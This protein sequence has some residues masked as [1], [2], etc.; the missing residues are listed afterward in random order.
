MEEKITQQR[1][2]QRTQ[3]PSAAATTTTTT[4][5]NIRSQVVVVTSG[6][7]STSRA[8]T[9][10][11]VRSDSTSGS[12]GWM[13]E[14]GHSSAK[15]PTTP[16]Q[17]SKRDSG[18]HTDC[19]PAPFSTLSHF[20]FDTPETLPEQGTLQGTSFPVPRPSL[21]LSYAGW[22]PSRIMSDLGSDDE[23][24]DDAFAS[25]NVPVGATSELPGSTVTLASS[26]RPRSA[27]SRRGQS[28]STS[29]NED[30][31]DGKADERLTSAL[32]HR[33]AGGRGD[34][35]SA[36]VGNS[37]RNVHF[38]AL[39]YRVVDHSDD[40][41]EEEEGEGVS[42]TDYHHGPLSMVTLPGGERI[43]PLLT[44]TTAT[45]TPHLH[46]QLIDQILAYPQEFPQSPNA[47]G[48]AV[49]RLR[50]YSEGEESVNVSSLTNGP[51]PDIV[52]VTHGHRERS[53]SAP[54]LEA[55]QRQR[56]IAQEV[57]RELRRISDDF[58]R[59]HEELRED[60]NPNGALVSRRLSM[61][62]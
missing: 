59:R 25:D 20:T 27:L 5:S 47:R 42:S 62:N 19:S 37:P 26:L 53:L 16:R 43:Q 61:L 1:R 31:T 18:Y 40:E 33:G 6:G 58:V 13:V 35:G 14:G 17:P 2:H 38:P 41:G 21:P 29:N 8:T 52:P 9:M 7:D 57:G 44:R 10:G 4:A 55:M 30:E 3:P 34:G 12:V 46:S 48:S 50:Y 22:Q 32:R 51:L 45:Q 49:R 15:T 36:S 23:G 24:D 54:D 11:R 28:P 39:R 56:A 60:P